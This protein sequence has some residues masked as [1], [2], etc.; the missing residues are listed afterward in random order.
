MWGSAHGASVPDNWLCGTY[1]I[2][3]V[4]GELLELSEKW[5][6]VSLETIKIMFPDRL[7]AYCVRALIAAAEENQEWAGATYDYIDRLAIGGLRR[8]HSK[9][10]SK[11]LGKLILSFGKSEELTCADAFVLLTQSFI[12][13]FWGSMRGMIAKGYVRVEQR[14]IDHIDV[15]VFFPTNRLISKLNCSLAS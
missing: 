14:E 6:S 7:E 10:A 11:R 12:N 2:Y 8:E 3:P 1:Q 4:E 13:L 9:I 5:D 15:E